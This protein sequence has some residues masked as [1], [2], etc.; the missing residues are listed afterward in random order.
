MTQPDQIEQSDKEAAAKY[1]GY[2]SWAVLMDVGFSELKHK[3]KQL[4]TLLAAHRRASVEAAQSEPQRRLV[5]CD[6]GLG[7]SVVEDAENDRFH[8]T[9]SEQPIREGYDGEALREFMRS[10][11]VSWGKALSGEAPKE[12]FYQHSSGRSFTSSE[13]YEFEEWD[14]PHWTVTPIYTMKGPAA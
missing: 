7:V 13:R 6:I 10:I 14:Q 1:L 5:N 9:V 2:S 12:W 8:I 3:G 4:A 11:V